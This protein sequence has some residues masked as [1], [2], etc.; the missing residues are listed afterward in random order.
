M[1]DPAIGRVPGFVHLLRLCQLG[2]LPGKVLLLGT[3][4]LAV[5]LSGIVRRVT[6]QLVRA[7]TFL[8]AGVVAV[9]AGAFDSVGSRPISRNLLLLSWRLLQSV[10]GRSAVLR[11]W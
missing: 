1:V 8:V 10:L 9:F 6:A 5:L 11:R 2:G 4:P 7:K 3:V